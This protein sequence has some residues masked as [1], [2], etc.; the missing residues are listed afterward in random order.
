MGLAAAMPLTR[1]AEHLRLTRRSPD[2]PHVHA[3]DYAYHEGNESYVE[4]YDGSGHSHL[5]SVVKRIKHP[6]KITVGFS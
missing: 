5:L 6:S 1:D 3:D 2:R 4:N